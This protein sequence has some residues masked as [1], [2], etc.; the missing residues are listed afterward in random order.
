MGQAKGEVG[1]MPSV[2]ELD[3]DRLMRE[4]EDS[5]LH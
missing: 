3:D 4:L 2:A 1:T 5:G